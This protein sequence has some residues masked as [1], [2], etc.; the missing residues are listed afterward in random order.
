MKPETKRA[1][2]VAGVILAIILYIVWSSIREN[3]LE[4]RE[5]EDWSRGYKA[6]YSDGIDCANFGQPSL[7][8]V[9]LD[10]ESADYARAY[11]TGYAEGYGAQQ[12]KVGYYD[13]YTDA[14]E[15]AAYKEDAK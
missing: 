8:N 3:R 15:G 11:L 7:D 4:D 10:G 1:L 9:E 12:Y 5:R 13:G 6:G 2:T 14:K